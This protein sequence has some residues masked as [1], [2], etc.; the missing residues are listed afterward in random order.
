MLSLTK[1]KVMG[2]AS[3][4]L[5]TKSVLASG[6]LALTLLTAGCSGGGGGSAPD[7]IISDFD[8]NWSVQ[9][10]SFAFQS[11]A[12]GDG[13]LKGWITPDASGNVLDGNLTNSNGLETA[14]NGGSLVMNENGEFN[15][16]VAAQ[17]NGTEHNFDIYSGKMAPSKELFAWVDTSSGVG[18]NIDSNDLVVAIKRGGTFFT[19]DLQ[20]TWYLFGASVG[21]VSPE[22]TV[23]GKFALDASGNVASG[24]ISRSDD[25]NLTA[26]GGK[27]NLADAG[28]VSGTVTTRYL[29]EDLN[30]TVN[31]GKMA[32]SKNLIIMTSHSNQSLDSN[33][34]IA[35]LKS[36]GGTIYSPVDL[37]GRWYLHGVS[38]DSVPDKQ[39]I[40]GYMDVNAHERITGGV[41]ISTGEDLQPIEAQ[42]LSGEIRIDENEKVVKGTV[43]VQS[44]VNTTI[45]ITYGRVSTTK[46]V[47]A[48]VTEDTLNVNAFVIAIKGE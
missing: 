38:M 42:I 1:E 24:E 36:G 28:E 10:L 43:L 12:F 17:S 13:N 19:A 27:I 23:W 8:G 22:G 41:Y 6:A 9:G 3:L 47:A 40:S 44:D 4:S 34:L 25:T 16:T 39:T 29:T 32:P 20:G 46:D 33:E 48:M 30:I 2:N 31:S 14:M 37:E 18:T 15:G 11:N 7:F 35:A 26:T 45:T 21:D 5:G